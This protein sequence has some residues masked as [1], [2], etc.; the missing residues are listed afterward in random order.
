MEVKVEYFINLSQGNMIFEEYLKLALLSKYTPS[1]VSNPSDEMS[2][3]VTGV[4]N[5]VKEKC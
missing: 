3:F 4:L 1:L 2:R 5:I